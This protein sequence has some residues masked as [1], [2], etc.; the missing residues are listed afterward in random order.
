MPKNAPRLGYLDLADGVMLLE[1]LAIAPRA[2]GRMNIG[3]FLFV[4]SHVCLFRC[5]GQADEKRSCSP[6]PGRELG[7]FKSEGVHCL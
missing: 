5:R 2:R 4:Y 7:R 6:L 1:I 3:A